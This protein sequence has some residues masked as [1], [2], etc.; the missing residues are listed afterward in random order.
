MPKGPVILLAII[1]LMTTITGAKISF[2][3]LNTKHGLKREP[4]TVF[5]CTQ[6][7][8]SHKHS[9]DLMSYLAHHQCSLAVSFRIQRNSTPYSSLLL[10]VFAVSFRQSYMIY[11]HCRSPFLNLSPLSCFSLTPSF[12]LSFYYTVLVYI[13][14]TMLI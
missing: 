13:F 11:A 1:K 6:F 14:H 8:K 7:R 4:T 12:E 10:R 2:S 5:H 3:V 9:N